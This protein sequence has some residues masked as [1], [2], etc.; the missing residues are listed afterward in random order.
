MT[1]LQ[2]RVIFCV[3]RLPKN[4]LEDALNYL[5][6]LFEEETDGKTPLDD[7]DYEL[8]RR[9]DEAIANGD[10]ETHSF[11]EVLEELGIT[12]GELGIADGKL[13]DRV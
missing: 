3:K 11:N 1:E 13:Q 7:F 12:C 4:K 2:N 10:T 9:A 6:E 5:T 8:S